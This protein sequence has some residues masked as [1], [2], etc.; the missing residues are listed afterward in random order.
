MLLHAIAAILGNDFVS[1]VSLPRGGVTAEAKYV[2]I[3]AVAC[4]T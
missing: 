2:S 1:A 4:G 3:S